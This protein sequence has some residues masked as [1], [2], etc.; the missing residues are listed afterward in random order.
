VKIFNEHFI[1]VEKNAGFP[2]EACEEINE[3]AKKLDENLIV[4]QKFEALVKKYMTDYPC[5]IGSKILPDLEALDEESGVHKYTLDLIFLMACSEILHERYKAKGVS[6]DIF[7]GFTIDFRCK[8]M[9]CIECKGVAGTF[10]ADWNDLFFSMER[11]ALGRFQYEEYEIEAPVTLAGKEI[12]QGTLC[13]NMHIPSMGIPL[14]DDVRYDSYKKAYDFFTD[15]RLDNG[16]LLIRCGSWLLNPRHKEFL[17]PTSN[18][19]K[20]ASDFKIYKEVVK[21]Y[22]NDDWRIWGHYA[23]LP[24]EDRPADTKLRKAY[25]DWML[26]GNKTGYGCGAFMFDGEKIIK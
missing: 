13:V 15:R 11:F 5:D 2:C 22:F 7:W 24:V 23:Q 14:T 18:I 1:A 8:L 21:D 4:N 20:F 10:V 6:D 19:L 25:K 3:A 26:A 9:E 16:C 17:Y 12:E